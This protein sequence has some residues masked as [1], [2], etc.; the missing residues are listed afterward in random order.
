MRP[1]GG[2]FSASAPFKVQQR[3]RADVLGGNSA[4][5]YLDRYTFYDGLGQ[6]IQTQVQAAAS[7]QLIL[8]QT[9]YNGV[10][11]VV[12]Q[13]VP[14]LFTATLGVY[15]ASDWT[16]PQTRTAYDGLGR[17]TAVTSPDGATTENRYTV[18]Y[19]PADPEFNLPRFAVYTIDANRHF[20]RRASDIFGNLR[21]VSE[22]TGS[23]PV[24]QPTPV[25]GDEYR[26]RYTY[27][28]AG[29]LLTVQDHAGSHTML[30]YDSLGRKTAMTDPDMG[31]WS[32]DY[33]NAGNLKR[34]TDA[35]NQT[36]CFYY[37]GLNRLKGK[38]YPSDTDCLTPDP[39][40][41][42]VSYGYDSTAGGNNGKG[43]RTSMTT[44]GTG[45]N[46]VSWVYDA[47]GRVTSETRTIGGAAYSTGYGYDAADRVR[48]TTYPDGEAV[49]TTYDAQG[50]PNGLSSGQGTYVSSSTYD[51]EGRL[52]LRV[53]QPNG[54][55]TDYVYYSWAAGVGD[56]GRLQQ[57]RSGIS[58]GDT[59]LQ[60]LT[61]SYDPV[62]NVDRLR[63]DNNSGQRQCFTFDPLDRLTAAFIG[64][65]NCQPTTVGAGAYRETYAYSPTGNL[66]SKAG[67]AYTYEDAAHVHAVTHI[68]AAPRACYDANGNQTVRLV[69]DKLHVLEYDAENRLARVSERSI[70]SA[71]IGR[72]GT[73]AALSWAGVSGATGYQVWR[74][75]T[76]YF[77]PGEAESVKVTT[78]TATSYRDA[79]RVGGAPDYY[80]I[81]ATANNCPLGVSQRLGE[82]SFALVPGTLAGVAAVRVFEA[83][84]KVKAEVERLNLSLNPVDTPLAS[85][86]YDADGRRVRATV[87]G[88]TTVYPFDHYEVAG[89]T[90]RKYYSLGGQRVA[91]RTDGAL[92]YLLGDHLGSTSVSTDA[93]GAPSGELRYLPFG[94]TRYAAGV[95]PTSF[96]FTGQR[97]DA[98]L[99]LYFF[100]ARYY[101][102]WLGRFIQADGLV[103]N[104]GDPQSL[105]RYAYALNNPLRYTDPTGHNP[106]CVV[107]AG[108]GPLGAVAALVCEVGY[109][110]VSYWPQIQ[111]LAADVAQFAASGQGQLAFQYAQQVDAAA[112]QA[113]ANASNAGNTAVPGGL[114]P[115]G[116]WDKF[117]QLL[118]QGKSEI[119]AAVEA[120]TQGSGDRFVIGPYK[121]GPGVANYIQ[122]ANGPIPGKYF[123]AGVKLWDQL[124]QK[125]QAEQVNR[126]V[127]YEQMKAGIGRI[128]ISSGYTIRQVLDPAI[129][130]PDKWLVKEVGWIQEFARIFGYIENAA[131]T[132]WIKP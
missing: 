15:R 62:G 49:I 73:S 66:I 43:R 87:A 1:A 50:L 24:G 55:Q 104:P 23:W 89:T 128:D 35:K 88:V 38:M 127:I 26:T 95:T 13:T 34:Q 123:D 86:T 75:T 78:T 119:D 14:A 125:G 64:D 12:T 80:L 91:V 30:T 116:P 9:G 39:G 77:T 20:V 63:D 82:F 47:R 112:N 103:P 84:A 85:F 10:G 3:Q 129:F 124:A 53:F 74:G 59:S 57:L 105:N 48:T 70:F 67:A 120:S 126:Q 122:E 2:Q 92:N 19:N 93:A 130:P 5:A 121:T 56:G 115:N 110:V 17:T 52:D 61:Y 117:N 83:E 40:S 109:A 37:D 94:G 69:G 21:V 16:Q 100:N 98:T 27:D 90:V 28:V 102:P 11:Q 54:L 99:G 36:T 72:S 71:S 114:G 18:E 60:H 76:P 45:T 4:A 111:A 6:V 31:A 107:M 131:G 96:R 29:R 25:W 118:G 42:E 79:G 108:G 22:S 113:A 8:T 58:S 41:Y 68:G 33:D 132:G 65:A 7:A 51:A 32:Y 46:D 101:D 97:E 81:L 106:S 44:T